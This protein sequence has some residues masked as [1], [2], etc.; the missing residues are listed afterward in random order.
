MS[1]DVVENPPIVYAPWDKK[2]VRLL[3]IGMA[4]K[5]DRS[6]NM[7]KGRIFELF[8]MLLHRCGPGKIGII[9]T[10]AEA[11]LGEI[12]EYWAKSVGVECRTYTPKFNHKKANLKEVRNKTLA[13]R[14]QL[15]FSDGNPTGVF[16]Y[17][18]G[19][20]AE[21]LLDI[22]KQ[23]GVEVY[24]LPEEDYNVPSHVVISRAQR[25]ANEV[26]RSKPKT[27]TAPSG[28]TWE[29]SPAE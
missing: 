19:N 20:S 25:K 2:E 26:Y 4:P 23:N 10:G 18:P 13:D 3:C 21:K 24:I 16:V 15:I 17:N 8:N 27:W 28:R 11:S 22:A 1:E 12:A 14:D 5:N 29:I 9:S 7:L 6:Y